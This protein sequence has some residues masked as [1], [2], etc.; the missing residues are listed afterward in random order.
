[1]AKPTPTL[2]AA[3]HSTGAASSYAPPTAWTPAARSLIVAFVENSLAASP[4]DPTSVTGHGVSFTKLTLGTSTLGT[5][6]KISVWVANSGTSPTSDATTVDFG[7]VAQTGCAIIEFEVPGVNLDGDVILQNPTASGT[8][9][10]GSITLAPASNSENTQ[11]AFFVHQANE[12]TTPRTNW[13]EP[14]GADGNFSSPAT[15]AAA[16]YRTDTFETTASASWT[17]SSA[18]IGVVLELEAA[19]AIV[20]RGVLSLAGVAPAL[21]LAM[22]VGAGALGLAGPAPTTSRSGAVPTGALSLTGQ[23]PAHAF[24]GAGTGSIAFTGAAPTL[25]IRAVTMAPPVGSLT[26]AGTTPSILGVA[27]RQPG[28][29]TLSLSGQQ[30]AA[31]TMGQIAALPGKGALALTGYAPAHRFSGPAE[32][33]LAFAGV[34]PSLSVGSTATTTRAPTTG[35]LTFASDDIEVQFLGP[36]AGGLT[37]TGVA[38]TVLAVPGVRITLSTGGLTLS[39]QTPARNVFGPVSPGTAVLALSGPTP[40][41]TIVSTGLVPTAA[42]TLSGQTPSLGLFGPLLPSTGAL[43]LAGTTPAFGFNR[44]AFPVAG[45]LS[46]A[47]T[48]PTLRLDVKTTHATGTLV[49]VGTL[50]AYVFAGIAQPGTG[51]IAVMGYAPSITPLTVGIQTGVLSL[52]GQEAIVLG[53]VTQ[54]TTFF[55]SWVTDTAFQTW[56]SSTT[57]T[58]R[59]WGAG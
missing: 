23:A 18:W 48:I 13:T 5:T 16:Q 59:T 11:L 26:L 41:L 55:R 10:S 29:G 32:G 9:T 28:A 3:L 1:M 27:Q 6:H 34:A 39:G 15:G 36:D 25:A 58:F 14:T 57:D 31:L 22:L 8:G 53:I 7:G 20:S 30:P 33:S 54:P 35:A 46:L 17:T 2:R 38:P 37:L 47:G 49:L 4:I 42:L 56:V 21:G 44:T 52:S 12:G 43:T 40:T 24:A 19:L 45:A 50:P 51:A